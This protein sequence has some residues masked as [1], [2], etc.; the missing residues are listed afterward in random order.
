MKSTFDPHATNAV[1]ISD[2]EDLAFL[3]PSPTIKRLRFLLDRKLLLNPIVCFIELTN[4][5]ATAHTD[6]L[7]FIRGARLTFFK[8]G[9][10]SL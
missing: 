2:V 8:E 9:W 7:L 6:I 1:T 5:E 4:D 3:S 10:I